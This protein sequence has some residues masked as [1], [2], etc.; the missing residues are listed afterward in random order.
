M[1][2]T[3]LLQ[4][5][6]N[7]LKG[8]GVLDLTSTH[9]QTTAGAGL[10]V[11]SAIGYAYL[12]A[13]GGNG[14]PINSDSVVNTAVNANA[15][16]NPRIT[17]IVLYK[18]LSQTDA[19]PHDDSNSCHIIAVDGTPAASPSAPSSGTIQSAC[20]ASNPWTPLA[21]CLVASGASSLA[22]QITDTRTQATWRSDLFNSDSWV[23]VPA[24]GAT[25]T[26]DLSKGKKFQINLNTASTTLALLNVPLNCKSIDVRLTQSNGGGSTVTFWAN[27]AWANGGVTPTLTV[28]NGKSDEFAINFLTV[29][30]DSVNTSE[31]FVA[32]QNI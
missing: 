27:L 25:T 21:N 31:G 26:L 9:F 29:V 18:D 12:L 13:S 15:S 11:N 17:T 22:G 24:T 8:S 32:G 2:E 4:L 10:S 16:G 23:V 20:G 14:Y 30:N 3:S 5:L 7:M 6:T 19:A 1:T 28:A